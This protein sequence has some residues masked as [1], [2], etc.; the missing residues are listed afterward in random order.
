VDAAIVVSGRVREE[1]EDMVLRCKKC[2]AQE[3]GLAYYSWH[4]DRQN[5]KLWPEKRGEMLRAHF[6]FGCGPDGEELLHENGYVYPA[7]YLLEQ[8]ELLFHGDRE[9]LAYMTVGSR[10]R[11]NAT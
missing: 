2:D 1:E 4:H 5:W 6:P 9:W 11:V 8:R 7:S 3:Q 10:G